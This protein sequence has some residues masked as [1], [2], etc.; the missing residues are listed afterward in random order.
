MEGPGAVGRATGGV[1]GLGVEVRDRGEGDLRLGRADSRR[2][3]MRE[4]IFETGC[5]V[6][7]WL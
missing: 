1:R 6:W 7:L 5:W 3:G 4:S 2:R